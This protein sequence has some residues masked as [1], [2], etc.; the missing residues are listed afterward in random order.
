[1]NESVQR[2]HV[3]V[4]TLSG[5]EQHWNVLFITQKD[6]TCLLF[7]FHYNCVQRNCNLISFQFYSS[8]LNMS[9]PCGQHIDYV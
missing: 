9:L 3:C 5:N 8:A 2:S 7:C 6:L 4:P 1:M